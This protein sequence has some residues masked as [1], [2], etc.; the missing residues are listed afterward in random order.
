VL[1]RSIFPPLK[2]FDANV[3]GDRR[4]FSP[5]RRRLRV[6]ALAPGPDLFAVLAEKEVVGFVLRVPK[7]IARRPAPTLQPPPRPDPACSLPA[8]ED[9]SLGV[10]RQRGCALRPSLRG[11]A[12]APFLTRSAPCRSSRPATSTWPA[13]GP[14]A[15]LIHPRR[16]PHRPRSLQARELAREREPLPRVC[17]SVRCSPS[18]ASLLG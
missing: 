12:P 11:P 16:N 5:P 3:A 13:L 15:S 4:R 18:L 10:Q 9:G 17:P 7:P 6:I 2:R 8:R 14:A 1:L